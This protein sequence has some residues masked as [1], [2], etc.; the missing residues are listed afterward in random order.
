[1]QMLYGTGTAA[2]DYGH[3]ELLQWLR[4]EGCHHA[5]CPVLCCRSCV[6]TD[7]YNRLP[8]VPLVT[9]SN[10]IMETFDQ[11]LSSHRFGQWALGTNEGL[12][13]HVPLSQP[14]PTYGNCSNGHAGVRCVRRAMR[15]GGIWSSEP[16]GWEIF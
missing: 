7:Y 6:E 1:M 16:L 12:L 2:A 9:A 3:L 5:G 10:V 8:L 11:R 13:R 14:V 15:W 4:S